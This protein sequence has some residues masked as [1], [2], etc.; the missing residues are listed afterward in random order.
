M[1]QL[2]KKIVR[3][4]PLGVARAVLRRS[5]RV[6]H[7][8]RTRGVPEFRNPTD[9]E[10]ADIEDRLRALG[11]PCQDHAVV[12][13][14]FDD[15]IDHAGFPPDYHGGVAGG[16]YREKLL[17]HYVAWELLG[18]GRSFSG[19]YVDIAACSSPWAKLLRE[20]GV[21]AYAI[22]LSVP[23]EHAGLNFYL[24]GDA[25]R[26]TFPDGSI[27][28]ASLQ[29]AYEMFVGEHDVELLRELA[30]VLAPGGRVVI[31]PLYTHTHA[32]FYQTP[33][34]YGRP[35]GDE[36]AKAYLRSDTWGVASSRKYS[37]ETLKTRVWDPAT[38]F[39]LSPALYAL[40]NKREIGEDIYLHFI[41]VLDKPGARF[42]ADSGGD[43]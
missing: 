37:P 1:I 14:T 34:H 21:E 41:L 16:V 26:M 6:Y 11:I 42:P 13:A 12:L 33:E 9:A 24:L 8:L 22:D 29:C 30:R 15:F 36:G 35:F 7:R 40:R 3:L 27:A 25:T 28:G 10:L 32:C 31:S 38:E 18:L 4:G 39:G 43:P 2:A 20:R 19:N 5:G 17:E 23:E